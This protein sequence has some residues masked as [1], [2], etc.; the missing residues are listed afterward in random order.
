MEAVFRNILNDTEI[1]EIRQFCAKSGY[2]ALEQALGFPGILYTAKITYFYL[3]DGGAIKSF[4]QINESFRFAQIWFGPVCDDREMMIESVLRISEYYSK[5]GFWYLGIQPYRN[6]GSDAD[7]IE[8]I[9]NR[10]LRIRYLYTNENTKSS[11]ELD[12]S[13]SLEEIRGNFTKGHKS[14]ISKALRYGITVE[15]MKGS[16]DLDFFAHVYER[17]RGSRGITGHTT[18]EVRK[19]C[20][21]ILENKCGIVLLAKTPAS[22]VIG[23]SV[24]VFQGRSVRYLLSASDPERRE[25]PITHLILFRA[26]ELS[27]AASF[28]YFDFWGYNHFARPGDQLYQIN[29]FKKGF[30]GYYT[31]LMKK[32]N[33]S[34]VPCGFGIFRRYTSVRKIV[35]EFSHR[36]NGLLSGK[37]GQ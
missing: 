28:R 4:S 35:F 8:Y 37:K 3:S 30:G 18:G 13:R 33:I 36:L 2:F 10:R 17:M 1:G 5:R 32:M 14:A 34:L 6:S 15:E 9:L 12:L 23:G 27:K 16:A 22:E 29:K 25:L 21:Y 31:F 20:S 19:I 26:I 24:F 11:I 7:Y